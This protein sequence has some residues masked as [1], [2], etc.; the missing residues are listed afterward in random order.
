VKNIHS[1]NLSIY[2]N[3]A[4]DFE[5]ARVLIRAIEFFILGAAF[6]AYRATG[7]LNDVVDLCL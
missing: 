2:V 5:A 1:T 4:D 6:C 7:D 3:K